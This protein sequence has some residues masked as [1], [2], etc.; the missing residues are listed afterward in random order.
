M[1]MLPPPLV[2][3]LA[4]K[5]IEAYSREVGHSLGYELRW[6]GE[7]PMPPSGRWGAA[8]VLQM[9]TVGVATAVVCT[10]RL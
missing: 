9:S 5:S 8:P 1:D 10:S 3:S 2:M 7:P 6:Q 4:S